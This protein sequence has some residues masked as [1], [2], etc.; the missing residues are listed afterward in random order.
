MCVLENVF[1]YLV[2]SY[3]ISNCSN[4]LYDC[5]AHIWRQE[6]ASLLYNQPYYTH[7]GSFHSL[8]SKHNHLHLSPCCIVSPASTLLI[9]TITRLH[10]EAD[11]FHS[12]HFSALLIFTMQLKHTDGT[13]QRAR[14][15]FHR[16]SN[17]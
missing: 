7:R 16:L 6:Q 4:S 11:S 13:T 10:A 8:I 2:F 1:V 14:V 5:C 17:H 12:G 15:C 3:N 9:T